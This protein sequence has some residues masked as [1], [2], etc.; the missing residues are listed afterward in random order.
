MGPDDI[1]GL[2]AKSDARIIV[3]LA[4]HI[5]RAMMPVLLRKLEAVI[6]NHID[7]RL[8]ILVTEKKDDSEL[9]RL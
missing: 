4:A 2:E 3:Q 9:R 5:P 1:T 7:P 6:Q 8:E